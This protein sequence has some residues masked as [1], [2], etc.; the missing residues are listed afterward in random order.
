MKKLIAAVGLGILALSSCKEKPPYIDLTA[1]T[2]IILDTTYVVSS[3]PAAEPH[4]VLIE[5]FTG[6][7]CSNC[8]SAHSIIL[9]IDGAHTGRINVIGLM[10]DDFSQTLPTDSSK[11][12][13]RSS[14]ASQIEQQ[15]FGA[16]YAMP[17]A[18]IDRMPLGDANQGSIYQ[19]VNRATW[20]DLV[21]TQ[22]A[23]TDSIN[24][25]VVSTYD[26]TTQKAAIT[27]TVTYLQ[28]MSTQQSLSI[29]VVEDSFVDWQED[30]INYDTFYHFNDVFRDLVTGNPVGSPILPAMPNK[31]AGRTAMR[32]YLYAIDPTKWNPAH[33]RVIAFVTNASDGRRVYQSKQTKLAP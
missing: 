1:G 4:N 23:V 17:D 28:P 15:I 2:P 12:N 11:Y 21:N 30:G 27:T 13:F 22:L 14:V 9:G 29:A 8:P 26:P 18:G 5:D 7:T 6:P 33:M 24:L 20:S 16:L 32:T 3:I 10:P 25:S 31:E 19:V